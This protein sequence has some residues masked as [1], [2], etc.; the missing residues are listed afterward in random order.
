MRT[1]LYHSP[2]GWKNDNKQQRLT[3]NSIVEKSG[4][5]KVMFWLP[6]RLQ[7]KAAAEESLGLRVWTLIHVCYGSR[8]K[9]VGFK[10]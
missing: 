7:E 1:I 2:F 9:K 3:S 10:L 4:Q 6:L 5:Q 8:E